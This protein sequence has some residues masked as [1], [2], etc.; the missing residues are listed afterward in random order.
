MNQLENQGIPAPTSPALGTGVFEGLGGQGVGDQQTGPG[1][2]PLKGVTGSARVGVMQNYLQGG[3]A[4]E[5]AGM[6]PEE[7]RQSRIDIA[8]AALKLDM[9]KTAQQKRE[10]EVRI[11]HI[12]AETERRTNP[13]API[14]DW[15]IQLARDMGVP[16]A[17]GVTP[18]RKQFDDALKVVPP[19][20]RG[21]GAVIGRANDMATTIR[22][23]EVEAGRKMTDKEVEAFVQQQ[24]VDLAPIAGPTGVT[25]ALK[26]VMAKL[27][28]MR[29]QPESDWKQAK[30]EDKSSLPDNLDDEHD[31]GTE[32][33]DSGGEDEG[34][35]Y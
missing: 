3:G 28:A 1:M 29:S 11:K 14:D 31:A 22:L 17:A 21:V 12:Q 19:H 13:N 8:R 5:H 34:G 10:S 32:S 33:D 16:I 25:M 15:E 35:D 4:P 6:T 30:G 9:G 20:L 24:G 27:K 2:V 26:G 18:S 23:A 7:Y